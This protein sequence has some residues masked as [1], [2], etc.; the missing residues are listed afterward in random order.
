LQ[1]IFQ[2]DIITCQIVSAVPSRCPGFTWAISNL[3]P[4]LICSISLFP[5]QHY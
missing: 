2:F 5:I 4:I 3:I 1:F